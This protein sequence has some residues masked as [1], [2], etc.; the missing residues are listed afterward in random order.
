MERKVW[1][2]FYGSFVNPRVLNKAGVFTTDAQR[3]KLNG[4]DIVIEP[5]ATL[6]PSDECCVYGILAKVSH[7]DLDKLYAKD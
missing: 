1:T 6:K 3:G 5:R 4:W 7:A 2:F